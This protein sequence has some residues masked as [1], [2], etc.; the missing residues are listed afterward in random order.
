[1]TRQG[2]ESLFLN[3]RTYQ[4][5]AISVTNYDKVTV[6]VEFKNMSILCRIREAF[7][8]YPSP[9]T[10]G[11][12]RDNDADIGYISNDSFVGWRC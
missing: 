6:R 1:M 2:D 9:V 4:N 12:K 5:D 10:I 7:F 3:F 11:R 8:F